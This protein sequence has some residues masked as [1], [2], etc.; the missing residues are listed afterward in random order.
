MDIFN[1]IAARDAAAK[2]VRRLVTVWT[3]L[4]LRRLRLYDHHT[5]K[6]IAQRVN[7]LYRT[8]RAYADRFGKVWR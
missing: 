1:A 2:P 6:R 8:D 3:V 4:G 5:A 7:R